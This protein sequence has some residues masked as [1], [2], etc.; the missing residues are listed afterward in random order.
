MRLHALV[1]AAVMGTP[2]IALSYDPKIDGFVKEVEGTNI[3][4]IENFA[5]SDLVKAAEKILEQDN[6]SNE[7]LEHLRQKALENTQL[8]FGL[9][10]R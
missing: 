8:A 9:L 1:F 2:F 7:R 5:A 4:A 3:G 10:K 6:P